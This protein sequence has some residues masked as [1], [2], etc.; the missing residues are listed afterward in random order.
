M[1]GGLKWP[2]LYDNSSSIKRSEEDAMEEWGKKKIKIEK[3]K[4]AKRKWIAKIPLLE[5][6]I[7]ERLEN[8]QH[9]DV[10]DLA[11]LVM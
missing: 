5:T 4:L 10:G 3:V 8:T 2:W 7:E 9:L 1:S 11:H 6:G